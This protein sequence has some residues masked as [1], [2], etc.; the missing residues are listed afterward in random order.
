MYP[1]DHEK[2]VLLLNDARIDLALVHTRHICTILP[3][4][5]F[6]DSFYVGVEYEFGHIV[7]GA[8]WVENRH[9]S[10]RNVFGAAEVAAQ[11]ITKLGLAA[12]RIGVETGFPAGRCAANRGRFRGLLQYG[13]LARRHRLRDA[14]G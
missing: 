1:F 10:P 9:A 7:P 13:P 8:L 6:A 2:L 12:D 11:V 4:R 14:Q 3:T 5:N